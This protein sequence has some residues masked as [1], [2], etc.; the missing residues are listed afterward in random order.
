[1]S[2]RPRRQDICD[3]YGRPLFVRNFR[4]GQ[5]FDFTVAHLD[6]ATDPP[7]S[8]DD[9]DDD[10]FA[11]LISRRVSQQLFDDLLERS[12]SRLTTKQFAVAKEVVVEGRS[13]HAFAREC[14]VSVEALRQ[15][16]VGA[17]TF[18][19]CQNSLKPDIP[20]N[21][22]RTWRCLIIILTTPR[23]RTR[24]RLRHGSCVRLIVRPCLRKR[25][26]GSRIQRFMRRCA[27]AKQQ[28]SPKMSMTSSAI[29]S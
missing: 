12:R 14:G 26:L 7:D 25:R 9:T 20:R 11:R 23:M 28:S 1:M 6:W 2:R 21:P 16:I 13:L 4:S 29:I 24:S 5:G 15:R 8:E 19:C 17:T 22:S 10:P 27:R 18:D 3:L